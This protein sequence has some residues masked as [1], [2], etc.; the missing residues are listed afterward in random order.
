MLQYFVGK[1]G[2]FYVAKSRIAEKERKMSEQ[3]PKLKSALN[4]AMEALSI[5]EKRHQALTDAMLDPWVR[6][7]KDGVVLDFQRLDQLNFR[8]DLFERALGKPD[9]DSKYPN[10]LLENVR[11]LIFST[12]DEDIIQSTEITLP[13]QNNNRVYQLRF[14]KSGPDEALI[15]IREATNLQ[16]AN[17]SLLLAQED[18]ADSTQELEQRRADMSLLSEMGRIFQ[19]A[20][21]LDNLFTQVSIWGARLFPEAHGDLLLP[22][23]PESKEDAAVTQYKSVTSWGRAPGGLKELQIVKC[24]ALMDGRPVSA[25]GSQCHAAYN[26][27][28]PL[29]FLDAPHLCTPIFAEGRIFALLRLVWLKTRKLKK[30]EYYRQIA[31]IFSEQVG[32]SINNIALTRVLREQTLYD[33]LTQVYNR[34]YLLDALRRE[35]YRANRESYNVGI[36]LM[37]LD[38]ANKI[39]EENGREAV[40]TLMK[41]V[42]ALLKKI[43]RASDIICRASLNGFAL[44]LSGVPERVA[45]LRAE[46][47]RVAVHNCRVDFK[48]KIISDTISCGVS[49]FPI[50]TSHLDEL[51]EAAGDAMKKAQ[52]K[53]GNQ[54]V[55]AETR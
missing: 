37:E 32:L 51:L 55:C 5:A 20:G 3:N 2:S 38:S 40:D 28:L 8:E 27:D 30:P 29:E 4:A 1:D 18:M 7:Y 21:S 31:A 12:I 9:G 52:E 19:A 13:A 48:G 45:S 14:A 53:G 39:I 25:R 24:F 16:Q 11:Q 23:P 34:R 46:E 42:A 6:I 17:E 35:L 36:L 54:V 26:S 43:V 47:I 44:T 15:I 33:S 49:I 22:V 10:N 50:H 41:E